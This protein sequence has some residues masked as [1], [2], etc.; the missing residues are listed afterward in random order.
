MTNLQLVMHYGYA[1][2]SYG[3]TEETTQSSAEGAASVIYSHAGAPV[4][5]QAA[6]SVYAVA[7]APANL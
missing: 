2:G 3:A 6:P 7:A 5:T 4:T 1:P